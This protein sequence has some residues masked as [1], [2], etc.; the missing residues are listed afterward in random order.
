MVARQHKL[1]KYPYL[2]NLYLHEVN[3]LATGL[4]TGLFKDESFSGLSAFE[5]IL[6]VAREKKTI[7]K[8]VNHT[9]IG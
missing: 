4:K 8:T 6:L 7:E 2:Y 1:I 5:I 9:P 3:C